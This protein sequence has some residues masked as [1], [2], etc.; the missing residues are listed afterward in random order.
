MYNTY[1]YAQFIAINSFILT[2]L[3]WQSLFVDSLIDSNIRNVICV[4][5]MSILYLYR[6]VR[7]KVFPPMPVDA[8]PEFSLKKRGKI[9]PGSSWPQ[10]SSSRSNIVSRQIWTT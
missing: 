8:S 9:P 5:K 6:F 3:E 1:Q 2:F 7:S 10:G 4:S